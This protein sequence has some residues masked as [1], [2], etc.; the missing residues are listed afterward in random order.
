MENR[1]KILFLVTESWYFLSHR[2]DLA[3]TCRD[4]GWE[5]V[6]ATRVSADSPINEPGIRVVPLQM[7]RAGR[8]PLREVGTLVHLWRM[9]KTEKPDILHAVGLKPVLYGATVARFAGIKRVVT[10]LAGMGYIFMSASLRIAMIRIAL[11]RWLRLA[12]RRRG[13]WLVLQNGDDAKMLISGGVVARKQVRVVRGSGVDLDHYHPTPEPGGPP[14]F[15]VV[16]RML[17]DKG[18]REMVWAARELARH[19]I[20]AR[21]WLVGDPD[22]DNPTSLTK[23]DLTAW[24]AEGCV[25]WLGQQ[26]DIRSIWQQAHVCVLPSYREGLPK[27]L[28][29][30]AASGRPIITTDVPGC[31]E[32]VR[33]GVDG[34]LIPMND[35]CALAEAI[36]RLAGDSEL[37]H[38]MGANARARAEAEFGSVAIISQISELY[39]EALETVQ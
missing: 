36:A 33:D 16:S 6:V 1:R 12:L 18:I 29:E 7:N 39:A 17:A 4:R 24:H 21:I 10:A 34:L 20:H 37:R 31:R 32:V 38:R 23:A 3:R 11:V 14:I 30:A 5:V 35:W 27:A 8:H 22:P 13:V 28:L 25:E 19:R 26:N 15:A 2:L 9:L